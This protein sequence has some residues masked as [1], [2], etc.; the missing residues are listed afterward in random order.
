MDKQ[1]RIKTI[2]KRLASYLE[3]LLGMDDK[4]T[5]LDNVGFKITATKFDKNE[6][7][8]NGSFII[9]DGS[10]EISYLGNSDDEKD[11]IKSLLK[12]EGAKMKKT[13]RIC[14]VDISLTVEQL[15][16]AIKEFV[17]PVFDYPICCKSKVNS[18]IVLFN[19][20]NEGSVLKSSHREVGHFSNDWFS[21]TNTDIW[22][23]IPYDKERGFYHKQPVYCWDN[24]DSLYQ[25]TLRFYDVINNRTFT[26]DGL[27]HGYVYYNYSA[28][29]PEHMKEFKETK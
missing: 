4:I 22:E 19:G 21:H 25:V 20:R 7:A 15:K 1:K 8:I 24:D 18:D 3:V 10:E 17:K 16:E 9:R 29:I 2:N 26:F 23:E 14:G 6:F 12:E 27:T 11:Y 5:V 13:I 28:E